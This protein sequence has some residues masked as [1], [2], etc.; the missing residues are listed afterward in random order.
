MSMRRN[1]DDHAA[2]YF[3]ITFDKCSQQFTM[4][5]AYNR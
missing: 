3:G 5:I 4:I 2:N 1:G